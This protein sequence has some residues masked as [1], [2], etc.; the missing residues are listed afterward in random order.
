MQS[1]LLMVIRI[2]RAWAAPRPATC[3]TGQATAVCNA[4]PMLA[5]WLV[6]GLL[7]TH[8]TAQVSLWEHKRRDL[9]EA[10]HAADVRLPAYPT[11]QTYHPATKSRRPLFDGSRQYFFV[12]PQVTGFR[13]PKDSTDVAADSVAPVDR[14]RAAELFM[15]AR[16]ALEQN[17]GS[18]AFRLA[19]EVLQFDPNHESARRWLALPATS[20]GPPISIRVGRR[21]HPRYA[22]PAGQYLQIATPHFQITTNDQRA[23]ATRLAETLEELHT[24][25]EQ[26]FFD[27][28][29]SSAMLRSRDAGKASRRPGRARH[30]V[31]M[32]RQRDEYLQYV[33]AIEPKAELT[34]GYYHAPSRT[35]FFVG[36]DSPQVST[37]RHETTHQLFQETMLGAGQIGNRQNF[38][39]AEGMAL[40]MES[41]QRCRQ[42]WTVG[43]LEADRLQYARFRALREGFYVPLAALAAMDQASL[44]NDPRIAQIYSQAAGL[45]HF[46]MDGANGQYRAALQQYVRQ[47]YQQQDTRDSLTRLTAT[48]W[49]DLDR[50]YHEYLQVDDQR[51]LQLDPDIRIGALCLGGTTVSNAGFLGLP[52]LDAV[53][54]LD[55]FATRLSDEGTTALDRATKLEQL[56]LERT[57]VSDT[58]VARLNQAIGLKQ[59]DLS[60]TQISDAAMPTIGRLSQLESLWLANTQVSDEGLRHL[61][62]LKQLRVLDLSGTRCTAAGRQYLQTALPQL[63]VE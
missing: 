24:V 13:V 4:G 35:S 8:G 7:A 19:H 53:T 33:Q 54:W 15:L 46:L 58:T 39:I 57:G 5:W 26:L 60:G 40:Y 1:L 47:V 11:A 42:W 36:G 31:V 29:G 37:W 43:G 25:W 12:P 9:Y 34:R 28:W 17:N 61:V 56:N 22:W 44:Q 51:L 2:A 18:L 20:A 63:S 45:T 14:Q 32:F 30:Q 38:W 55:M 16:E 10:F 52:R 3:N 23:T 49:D 6:F 27:C 50:Q 62:H 21:P 48:A 41:M 59:L